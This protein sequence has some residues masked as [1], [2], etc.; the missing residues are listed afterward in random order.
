MLT[1]AIPGPGPGVA[2]Y[3]FQGLRKVQPSDTAENE[4]V[5][6]HLRAIPVQAGASVPRQ[7]CRILVMA[8]RGLSSNS[9]LYMQFVLQD[10]VLPGNAFRIAGD[11][12]QEGRALRS[13]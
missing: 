2:R 5:Q 13:I 11:H 4:Q 9:G 7:P 1:E 12:E 8:G 10:L 6:E 3:I